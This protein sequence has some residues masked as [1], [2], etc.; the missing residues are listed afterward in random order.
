MEPIRI[1]IKDKDLFCFVDTT[2][3]KVYDAFIYREGEFVPEPWAREFSPEAEDTDV[4]AMID[5]RGDDVLQ[6]LSLVEGHIEIL[7]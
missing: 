2:P 4:L 5:D 7:K 6:D 1:K 3:G